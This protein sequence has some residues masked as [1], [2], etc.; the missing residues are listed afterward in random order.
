MHLSRL[1][2]SQ[3]C[4]ARPRRVHLLVL[5]G[6]AAALVLTGC[7]FNYSRGKALEAANRWEEAA[8]EYHLAVIKDPDEPEFREALERAN[9][10]VARENFETYSRYLS[11][12]QFKKAYSRLLD[13]SRQ[14]PG[15]AP[16][17]EEL[18]KWLRV[19]VAGQVHFEFTSIRRNLSLADEIN[20][21]VRFNTPNPGE[22]VEAEID[23]NTGTFFVEDLLYERPQQMLAYYSINALGVSMVYGRGQAR[24]FTTKEFQRFVNY[25]TPV[26]DNVQGRLSLTLGGE[27]TAVQDHRAAI[28]ISPPINLTGFELPAANPHYSLRLS[29]ESIEAESKGV[30]PNFTPRF[31]YLNKA[32]RRMFVDFGRYEIR[33]E[34][35]RRKWAIRRRALRG[36]DYFPRFSQNIALRPYF[37]YREGVFTYVSQGSPGKRG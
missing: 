21:T 5:A 26:L 24:R 29:G 33:L 15:Y 22:T 20:L 17:R 14:D 31:L 19:L 4:A 11:Q 16:A 30:A 28:A 35:D 1:T 7:N 18:K 23:L 32:D 25:R 13:A 8:I 27:L 10:V 36:D 12:K 9:K 37:F 34:S 3:Q 2:L 6:L